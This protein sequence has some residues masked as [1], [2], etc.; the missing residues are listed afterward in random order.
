MV[1]EL[2]IVFMSVSAAIAIGLPVVLFFIWRRKYKLKAIPVLFGIAA[3]ILFAL[4]LE[5]IMHVLV[6]SPNADGSSSVILKNPVL[7]VLYGTMAAGVFEETARFLSFQ[8]L[9]KKHSGIG[10]GLAYGIG[11]G[12]LEAVFIAGL[13][14]ISNISV[15][16]VINN[17]DAALLGNDFATLAGINALITTESINFLASGFERILA[18]S[19]HVSLSVI[20]WC[21]VKLK[22]KLWL[23][24]A[25]IL[26]HAVFNIPATLYQFGV[27]RNIWL[28]EGLLVIPAVLIAALAYY[29]CKLMQSEDEAAAIINVEALVDANTVHEK[30]EGR[31]EKGEEDEGEGRREKGEEDEEDEGEEDEEEEEEDEEDDDDEN[32]DSDDAESDEDIV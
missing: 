22:G 32:N 31:R 23:Y 25:A 9:K 28:T 24:P 17:G 18:V 10:T 4:I 21:S 14:M 30:G 5:Q 20:V 16:I 2:S 8:I 3:F 11:H 12:G 13:A 26:L 19:V 15:S 1:P 29:F 7:F 6:L 27:I